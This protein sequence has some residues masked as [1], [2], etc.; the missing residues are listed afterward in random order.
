[1]IYIYTALFYLLLPFIFLRL[2][3]RSRRQGAY[4]KRWGER[5]GCYSFK[6]DRCL[7]VHAVSMGEVIAATP[8]IRRLQADYP[9]LPLLVTT[10]T[11]TGSARVI[12]TFGDSVHHVYVP[13]DMPAAIRRFLR[14]MNPVACVIMET[15]LWPN[16]ITQCH[17]RQ[18]P[19]CL[20]NARL[21][22]KSLHGYQRVAAFVR[23]A[24]RSLSVIAAHGEADARRFIELGVPAERVVVTGS[25]KFDLQL[26]PDL[27][28]QAETLRAGLGKNR[29][30]W[31]AASTH[32]GEEEIILTAHRQ[33]GE[34]QPDALLIL[35]PRH[36]ERFN[37][38]AALCNAAGK[39]QR[40]SVTQICDADTVIYLGD[41]M[42]E[43]MLMYG[44]SDA[45]FV[46]GS[47]I[48]RGGHNM[49]E[50]AAL[51]KPVLSGPHLF[52]FTEI[53]DML[54]QAQAMQITKD[55]NEL[56][57]ALIKLCESQQLRSEMGERARR[58]VE[59]NRGALAAQLAE[60]KKWVRE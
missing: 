40:R 4:R 8:L 31:I 60:I 51:A 38:V 7:W 46:G 14:A 50:P 41:T 11:P 56:A 37:V 2:L 10:M 12:S 1:M 23:P 15:E 3:W 19:V 21:S 29:F 5:L 54:V 52:N 34:T 53:A 44:A 16:L 49:L 32:E 58:V 22:E 20:M 6:L 39:T 24:L 59:S 13:Y 27:H 36:P 35:V 33:L 48:Q 17:Q 28:Q 47:L 55:A 43:L 57:S 9:G 26:A 45:A 42:G 25:I 30:V 18:I